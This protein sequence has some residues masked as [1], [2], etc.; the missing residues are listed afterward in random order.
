M[1]ALAIA[2]RILLQLRYDH[3]TLALILFAP[4]L[5]LTLIY[6]ILNS[7]T[8]DIPIGVINAPLNF[9]E[10]IYENNGR[11]LYMREDEAIAAIEKGEIT[12]AVRID[13]GKTTVYLDGSDSLTA[14]KAQAILRSAAVSSPATLRPDLAGETV[15][16]YG[17]ADLEQFDNFGSAMIGLI[18]FFLVFL[19]A[20]INMLGER[21]TGTLTRMLTAPVKRWEIV[22][23]YTLGFG[24][25]T[26]VQAVIL[27]VYII[28][29]LHLF[30]VGSLWLVM[31]IILLSS[32]SA[33]TMGMLLSAAA[34]GEFQFVQFIPI[35]IIPQMFFSGIFQLSEGWDMAGYC[36]P[37][38]YIADA[39]TEVMLR[40]GGIADVKLELAVLA[41]FSL[42][43]LLL[44]VRL[45]KKQ[46]AL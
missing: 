18:L 46:R 1:I 5:I 4:L 21:T 25:L 28:Y 11:P 34:N 27:S 32:L 29:V 26:L 24:M 3:R 23:G 33:M 43:F 19:I 37:V 41:G 40:G 9:V 22:L 7:D 45:L 20:G 8:Q 38:R 17:S 14:T 6:F 44:N 10:G 2:K 36:M 16:L 30:M 12:A 39:L 31:L 35:V 13:N 15:Y 42:V